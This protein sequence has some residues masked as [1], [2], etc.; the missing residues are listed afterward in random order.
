M[1]IITCQHEW[2]EQCQIRYRIDP[3]AG[4]HFENAHYPLSEKQGGISTVRLWYPDH[5]VQGVLQTLNTNYPCIHSKKHKIEREILQ[6]VYPDY[7][8]LYT[9]AYT[10]CQKFAGK[11]GGKKA[12]QFQLGA[13]DP[14]YIGSEEYIRVRRINGKNA[15]ERAVKLK[16]G[17]CDPEYRESGKFIEDSRRGGSNTGNQVWVS[18]IDGFRSTASGVARHNRNRG[19]DPDDRFRLL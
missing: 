11:R 12:A 15:G 16:T 14:A 17:I 6:Q 10:F 8:E 19:W 2:V 1:K 13:L 5:I 4:Y 3:P 18:L 7:V 9:Q